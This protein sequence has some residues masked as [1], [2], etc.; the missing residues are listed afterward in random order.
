MYSDI[1][2]VFLVNHFLRKPFIIMRS[3]R[4]DCP[5]TSFSCSDSWAIIEEIWYC[6]R[7]TSPVPVIP[8][9]VVSTRNAHRASKSVLLARV[10][11]PSSTYL[12][13]LCQK[14][15]VACRTDLTLS[16]VHCRYCST[17]FHWSGRK[18]IFICLMDR[19]KEVVRRPKFLAE[20]R[21]FLCSRQHFK[22][23]LQRKA[24]WRGH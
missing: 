3:I 6:S 14:P 10:Q 9:S 23:H 22:V 21:Y 17:A 18:V 12:C 20:D 4:R 8:E 1:W 7:R 11:C 24:G 2:S 15:F 19:V 13:A 5:L 16:W